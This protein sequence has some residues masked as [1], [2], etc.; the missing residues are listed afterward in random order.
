MLFTG[1][2]FYL[3]MCKGTNL[4][5]TLEEQF[6]LSRQKSTHATH[7]T[8]FWKRRVLK[9]VRTVPLHVAC[10]PP[11]PANENICH[12]NTTYTGQVMCLRHWSV[13]FHRSQMYTQLTL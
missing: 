11:P 13:S 1:N 4:M 10:P 9:I 12:G 6:Y 8:A 7:L 5:Y 3:I 2:A